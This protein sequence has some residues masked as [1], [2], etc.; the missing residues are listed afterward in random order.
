MTCGVAV[1]ETTSLEGKKRKIK[2]ENRKISKRTLIKIT[3][4]TI[5]Q[6]KLTKNKSDDTLH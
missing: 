1:I 4:V 3:G 5:D 2:H 6:S